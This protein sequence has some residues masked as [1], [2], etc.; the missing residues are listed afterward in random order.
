MLS[1][2]FIT[3]TQVKMDIEDFDDV[4][5]D[6][7]NMVSASYGGM[8]FPTPQAV[9]SDGACPRPHDKSVSNLFLD[10]ILLC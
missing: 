4:F 8:M 6:V 1:D 10:F 7:R 9:E 2:E 5:R 3:A